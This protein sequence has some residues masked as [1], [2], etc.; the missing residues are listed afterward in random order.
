MISMVEQELSRQAE[1]EARRA[2]VRARRL[3]EARDAGA[4]RPAAQVDVVIRAAG[5]TDL[6]A[7]AR[8]AELDSKP[9]PAGRLLVAKAAGQIRVAMSVDGGGTIAD[10]FA[11]TQPLEELLRLRANQV[12][13]D[14]RNERRGGGLLAALHL[15]AGRIA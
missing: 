5:P 6:P 4:A 2:G 7:L 11:V 8:L 15:R 1:L 3:R 13:R 9:L 12:R 14:R 10:P